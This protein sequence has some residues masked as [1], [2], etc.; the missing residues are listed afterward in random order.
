MLEFYR[1]DDIKA[2][3]YDK[4]IS[5]A[6]ET[7]TEFPFELRSMNFMAYVYHLKG[8]E[9]MAKKISFRV[10]K[11][12]EAIMSTGD[13]RTCES[14]WHVISTTHEYVALNM[15]RL[16]STSQALIGQN[17]DYLTL[18]KNEHN[19]EGL[20]FNIEQLFSKNAEKFKLADNAP[21]DQP[22]AIRGNGQATSYDSLISPYVKLARETLPSAKKSFLDGMKKGDTFFL[23]TRIYDSPDRFEQVFI[24]VTSWKGEKIRGTIANDL[25]VVK[26]FKRGQSIEFDEASVLDWTIS[27][28][29]GTEEGNFIGKFLDSQQKK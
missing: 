8:N 9:A 19:V 25:N 24:H 27:K 23:T 20:Y 26:K 6:E 3:D 28:A 7:L 22:H 1:A 4:I 29:D 11:I 18:E 17:C 10:G 2:K 12:F 14:S 21:K 13:G 5:L 15:F 16:N